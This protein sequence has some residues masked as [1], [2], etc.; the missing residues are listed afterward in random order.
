MS[1]Y[2][3]PL[4]KVPPPPPVLTGEA[5]QTPPSRGHWLLN[6]YHQLAQNKIARHEACTAIG[7]DVAVQLGGYAVGMQS[8]SAG[9]VRSR[10]QKVLLPEI[11]TH[12]ARLSLVGDGQLR[13]YSPLKKSVC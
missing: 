9:T 6:G 3:P 5:Y 1:T 10:V 11:C 13:M 2:S 7:H 8:V 4:Y 12:M